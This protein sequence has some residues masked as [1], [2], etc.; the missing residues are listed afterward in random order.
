MLSLCASFS[1][2][3]FFFLCLCAR[4]YF[5]RETVAA[6]AGSPPAKKK[7]ALRTVIKFG[8]SSLATSKRLKEVC[9][10]CPSP[11]LFFCYFLFFWD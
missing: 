2:L 3:V 11:L 5:G 6:A 8:G 7:K 4:G 9:M 10:V 1:T